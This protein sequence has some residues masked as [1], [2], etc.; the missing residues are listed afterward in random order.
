MPLT[1]ALLQTMLIRCFTILRSTTEIHDGCTSGLAFQSTCI[2]M[3][4]IGEQ[5]FTP[6]SL[7][8]VMI[9]WSMNYSNQFHH[10]NGKNPSNT[11]KDSHVLE[12]N[13][14]KIG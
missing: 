6:I 2:S 8:F 14:K 4:N 1:P 5:Y 9:R 3:L 13:R 10:L 12:K 7:K 11:S